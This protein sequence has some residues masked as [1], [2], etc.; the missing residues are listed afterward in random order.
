[1]KLNSELLW[2]RVNC[3]VDEHIR[4]LVTDCLAGV[5]EHFWMKPA[6]STGHHHPK[7]EHL[8]GGLGLH[9]ARVVDVLLLIAKAKNFDIAVDEAVAAC[10][11]HDIARYGINERA[12][13]HSLNN[14]A[15]LGEF[16]FRKTWE[17]NSHEVPLEVADRIAIAIGRHMGRWSKNPPQEDLDWIVHLADLIASGYVPVKG[18]MLV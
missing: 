3:I 7:D 9:T 12:S 8:P 5:P 4:S 6:S 1:M 2:S 16:V 11:L 10:I 15:E 18:E 13:E 17:Q 14:H